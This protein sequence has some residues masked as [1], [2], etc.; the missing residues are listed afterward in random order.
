M[1][2]S[3]FKNDLPPFQ[4][5]THFNPFRRW[6]CSKGWIRFFAFILR[7]DVQKFTVLTLKMTALPYKLSVFNP[8]KEWIFKNTEMQF[9]WFYTQNPNTKINDSDFNND[10]SP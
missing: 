7:I 10:K 8:L 3:Y 1:Y 2:R 6:I 9:C 5:S 4:S